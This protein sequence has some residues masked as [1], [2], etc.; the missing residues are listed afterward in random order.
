MQVAM[1]PGERGLFES[2]LRAARSYLEFGAGGSTRLAASLVAESV[3]SVDSSRE[4]LDRVRERCLA[5]RLRVAP[6]LLHV[7]IGETKDWGYPADESARD[8]WLD[9]HGGIWSHGAARDADL[10]LVDGRFRVACFMQVL[11]HAR[12]DALIAIH[13]FANR[14]HDQV[15]RGMA[16][17]IATCGN[18]SVFLRRRDHDPAR[19]AAILEEHA[20]DPA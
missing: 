20:R 8:R 18:L 7:S 4:W 13:D 1:S 11:L 19:I 16:R 6:T 2:L 12:P 17:E 9:C 3:I 14:P 15:I 10:Y 5:S